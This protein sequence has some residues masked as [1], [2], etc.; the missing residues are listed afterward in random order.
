MPVPDPFSLDG[1]IVNIEAERGRTIHLIPVPDQLLAG[2][3]LCGLWIKQESGQFDLI[4]YP[5]STSR[6]HQ[7]KIILH[8]LGHLWCDDADG[9][10]GEE[11]AELLGAFSQSLI[12]KLVSSKHAAARRRYGT[13]REVRAETIA[14]LIHQQAY[15]AEFVVERDDA[16]LRSLAESLMYPSRRRP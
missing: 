8:E 5:Q 16:V 4:F 14:D 7:E 15:T 10:T 2:S 3:S 6:F 11:A 12:E 9:V 13:H 1:L